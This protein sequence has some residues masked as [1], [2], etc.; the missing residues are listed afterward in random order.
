LKIGQA[1]SR[2]VDFYGNEVRSA[3][4]NGLELDGSEGN[5]RAFRNRFTNTFATLSFQPVYGGPAYAL[6]NVIVNVAHGQLKFHGLGTTPPQEP[7]GL[8]VLHNTFVS[9][10]LAL[11]LQ[12]T[13]T[14]HHFVVGG[15]VFVGP[16]PPGA[17]V[18][19]WTGSMNAG[20]FDR[21]GWFPD[22]TFDFDDAGTWS[23]FAAMQAAGVL[24]ANGTLLA[25]GIFASGLVAPASHTVTMAP[26]D[27]SLAAGSS[28]VDRGAPVPNLTD[29]FTGAAPDLGALERG[30][31]EPFFGVR[32]E[33]VDETNEPTGCGGPTVTTTTSPTTTT[34]TL[35]WVLVRT[36]ALSLRDDATNPA[37]RAIA[38]RSSTRRDAGAHRVVPPQPGAAGD[39]TLHG[40]TL[41]VS[42]AATSGETVT[43]TLSASGW[44]GLGNPRGTKGY[45]FRS[46]DSGVA[47]RSAI[48]RPDGISVKG[49][50]AAWPFTLDEPSQGR[51]AVALALGSARPWCAEAPARAGAS[52]DVPGRFVAQPNTPPPSTCAGP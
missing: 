33:G 36:T 16:S 25:P 46:T 4:D 29:A 41:T 28:A 52:N 31:P 11:N 40:A 48:V 34:T 15:N 14:T 44:V 2:A 10:A 51:I 38:F 30:C 39:P 37:R 45:R 12:T 49:G 8:F 23:S 21:N 47:I 22:G 50:N 32:P 24:E 7:S 13:A 35:P 9:P 6:R 26:Q 18:V 5:V 1:G 20:I 27:V 19:E 3:Y 43:V 42:N 17:R